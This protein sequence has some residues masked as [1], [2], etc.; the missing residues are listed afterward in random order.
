METVDEKGKEQWHKEEAVSNFNL[1]WDLIDKVNR[2]KEEDLLMI[3]QAHASR[4]H[5]GQI[6][7]PIELARG[8]WQISRVYALLQMGESALYHAEMC[9][10]Y[11]E[12]NDIGDF[13]LAFA[14]EALARAYKVSKFKTMSEKYYDLAMR[15]ADDIEKPEDRNHFLSELGTIKD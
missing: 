4:F 9:L 10:G 14:Y 11:C 8:E 7:T 6:G 12:E 3:H 1:T 15:A 2:S 13:D 5:W